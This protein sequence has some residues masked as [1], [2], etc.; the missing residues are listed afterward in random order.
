MTDEIRP[1]LHNADIQKRGQHLP[2]PTLKKIKK[3]LQTLHI[4]ELMAVNVYRFQITKEPTEHNR[5]LI[6]AMC[7]E[8]THYQDF[9]VKLYEY[10]FKPSIKRWLFWFVGFF[11][12]FSSR[13]RGSKAILRMGI[14]VEE[15]AVEHY[16]ELLNSVDWDNDTRAVIEKNQTDEYNHIQNWKNLLNENSKLR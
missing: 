15:K 3:A 13:I 5:Q 1:V 16:N 6:A 2:K 14:W 7:N 11:F 8:M 12:G 9:Q 4:F 10:S